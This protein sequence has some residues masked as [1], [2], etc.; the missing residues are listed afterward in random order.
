MWYVGIDRS[1]SDWHEHTPQIGYASSPDGIHWTRADDPVLTSGDDGDWDEFGVSEANVR[2]EE[3]QYKMWFTGWRDYWY[4]AQRGYATSQDGV[5]WTQHNDNPVL[6]TGTTGQLGKPVVEFAVGSEGSVLE[7]FTIQNGEAPRGGGILIR[8]YTQGISDA[9]NVTVRGCTVLSNT[10]DN[11]GGVAIDRSKAHLTRSKVISN[12]ITDG[13]GAGLLASDGVV[14]VTN[15][16]IAWNRGDKSWNGDGIILWDSGSRVH[17]INSTIVS[18]TAEG[19]DA[20]EGFVDIRNTVFVGNRGGIQNYQSGATVTSDFNVFWNNGWPYHNVTQGPHDQIADPLFIDVA[21]GDF[22]IQETSP[23]LDA[24]TTDGAPAVDIRG[25]SRDA[26]PD[27]GAYE[28][29][30]HR[31]F[32]PLTMKHVIQ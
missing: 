6:T 8:N 24:G 7:G 11:G 19:V 28:R 27:I 4:M 32:L 13:G 22:R 10:A 30:K 17:I 31:I 23:C 16:V 14:T 5:N 25:M 2:L 21:R 15:A 1:A 12:A 9:E 18:N 3:G 20:L 29:M 26:T